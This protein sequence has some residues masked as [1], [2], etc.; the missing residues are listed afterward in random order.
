MN[1]PLRP[2]ESFTTDVSQHVSD[3]AGGPLWVPGRIGGLTV[4]NRF[5]LTGHG[6]GMVVDGE[7]SQ[8]MV[9][10]YVERA[11]GGV[12]LIML[13]TQQVHPSSPGLGHLLV[14]YDDDAIPGLRRVAQAVHAH[15]AL[16][17]GYIGHFGAQAPGAVDRPWTASEF[18]DEP[19][20]RTT[21][22]MSVDEIQA[23]VQATA[24]AAARNVEAGLDGIEV[25][26]GH[27]LLLHQF[28]SPWTNHRT[29]AYGGSLEGRLRFPC[30]VVAAVRKRIGPNVALGMRIS[31]MESVPGGLEVEDMMVIV[32]RLVA[33]GQLDFVD[34]TAGNDRD[35]VSNMLHH[36]AMGMAVAPY[37]HAARRIR[38]TIGIP[39][40]HGTR[41]EGQATA[42]ELVLSGAA[43]FAGMVR[44][45][46]ADP[47]LPNKI[48][49]GRAD[50]ANP[51]VACEQACIGRL[52]GGKHISCVGNPV[53]G[54]ETEWRDN[55]TAAVSRRVVVVGAGPAGMEAAWVAAKRGHRVTVLEREAEVG[56]LLRLAA[57][58]PGRDEWRKLIE[59]KR[60][61]MVEHGVDLRLS[62]SA[63]VDSVMALAPDVII[64]AAGGE[65]QSGEFNSLPGAQSD[66]VL[67]HVQVLAAIGGVVCEKGER[68]LV[69]DRNNHQQGITTALHLAAQ[70]CAVSIVTSAIRVGIR[71]D[72][73][74]F[75]RT[76]QLLRKAGIEQITDVEAREIR[77][78]SFIG[79]DVF[80]REA[81]V[82]SGFGRFVTVA[83]GL[84]R[85]D[86]SD[87]LRKRLMQSDKKE[88]A[89][90]NA[91]GNVQANARAN[92]T[93]ETSAESG[94]PRIV[95]SAIGDCV[96][97]RD[98][99][100]AIFEGHR[101]AR[102]IA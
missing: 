64:V 96:A 49:V 82:L 48:R 57:R 9:D 32:P 8:Q 22:G 14:N 90:A 28:L 4:R 69:I 58:A 46:I 30:E 52:H 97:P 29:D 40:I 42:E 51:C 21:H 99:E 26:A 13:G 70:G 39:V 89:H 55:G 102:E 23:I 54:R 91:Q 50:L 10:Y 36:P 11:R 101:A 94:T 27:G 1:S 98:V 72:H 59:H 71:L 75:T 61:Q 100:A 15:G 45:L 12:G 44:A 74:N 7:P 84:P 78:D 18:Y 37:A 33:A 31:G 81:R 5:V 65:P 34:I 3:A 41:I 63:D 62:T 93:S 60:L 20:G 47:H 73:A 2:A 79:R 6:T 53:T 86:L 68:V 19:Q 85:R 77:D 88:N 95:L 87:A 24:D 67:S 56:G 66:K 35:R 80:S 25:H 17:F 83:P 38:E 43:D 92:A 76:Q 16:I